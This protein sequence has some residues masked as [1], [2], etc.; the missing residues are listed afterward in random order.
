[1]TDITEKTL[2]QMYDEYLRT[3]DADWMSISTP[4]GKQLKTLGYVTDNT[5][6]DFKLTS[7]GISYF[8]S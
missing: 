8:E 4:I 5:Q 1:M 6:G 3:K 7:K 2:K